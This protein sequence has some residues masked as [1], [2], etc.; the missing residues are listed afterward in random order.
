LPFRPNF[1]RLD[2]DASV[3]CRIALALYLSFYPSRTRGWDLC[4]ASLTQ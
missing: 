2:C 4:R 3:C 1:S